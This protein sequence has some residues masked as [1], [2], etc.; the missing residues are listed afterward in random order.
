MFENITYCQYYYDWLHLNVTYSHYYYNWLQRL[1]TL[2][3][4][5]TIMIG[6]VWK[7]FLLPIL[8]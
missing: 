6:Y 7:R 2:P 8:I 1:K 3:T 4:A 5:N